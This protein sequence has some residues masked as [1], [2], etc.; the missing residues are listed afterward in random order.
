MNAGQYEGIMG[1]LGKILDRHPVQDVP[2]EPVTI[3][4]MDGSATEVP[5]PVRPVD[6]STTA[7]GAL[8]SRQ[9][10]R[11]MRVVLDD[12]IRGSKENHEAL[13][14]RMEPVGHE[15]WRTFHTSDIRN[16]INDAARELGLEEFPIPDKP[17]ED[18]R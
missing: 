4:R 10:L 13:G 12:W 18:K 9:A 1:V 16:M 15:C 17:V 6:T 2:D 8:V 3:R 11:V 7:I 14:H 5:A